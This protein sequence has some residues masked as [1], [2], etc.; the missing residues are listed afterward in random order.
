MVAINARVGSA[1]TIQ[2]SLL[3]LERALALYWLRAT[4]VTAPGSRQALG[5]LDVQGLAESVAAQNAFQFTDQGRDRLVTGLRLGRERITAAVRAGSIDTL[6]AAA[7]VEGFRRRLM[8]RAASSDPASVVQ[9]F[10]LVEV[11][12]LGLGEA[13]LPA[14][15]HAWGLS[16]RVIDGR[17]DVRMPSRLAWHELAGRPGQ[18]LLSAHVADLPLRVAEWLAE[19][20]LPAA[21]ARGVLS[22]A[23]WDL[24]VNTQ[25]ADQDDWLSVVRAAQALSA[26]RVADHVSALTAGGP[27]V[28]VGTRPGI[29]GPTPHGLASP[30]QSQEPC[31]NPPVGPGPLKLLGACLM[32][33]GC[34]PGSA[35]TKRRTRFAASRTT[36]REMTR[37][38]AAIVIAAAIAAVRLVAAGAGQAPEPRLRILSPEDGSYAS[39][40]ITIRATVEPPGTAVERMQFFGEGRLV[41]TVE[42]PPFECT[43]NAGPELRERSIR[44]V[45]YLP[46]GRRLP[47]TIH[48]KGVEL[49]LSVDVDVVRVTVVV[50]DGSRFVRGL[51][52][53]AF[54]VFEDD[55]RQPIAYFGAQNVPLEL[56]TGVDVSES[57]IDALEQVKEVVKRFLSALRPTDRVHVVAFNENFFQIA[58]PSVTLEERLRAVDELASWGA[59][60]L[61][62]TIIRSFDL[63]GDQPNRRGMVMF[64][65]GD[66]TASR[67][68]ADAVERRAESSDAVLYMIGQG[69]AV[70]SASLRT[71]CERLAEK[72]G[73]RAF[74]PRRV[75]DLGDT[76]GQILEDLSNQYLL[77]YEPPSATRDD[78]WHRI[79]VEVGDGRY[80][81]RARQGYRFR[82]GG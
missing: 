29:R 2:G 17:F 33:L 80:R 16:T 54:R 31:Q 5:Q 38:R 18:G 10:S 15:L 14:D 82:T 42:K 75:Q 46:G 72:S 9:R 56:V 21:L 6:A 37:R 43:W 19:L 69:R 64:T 27:L 53:S 68:P 59:T 3:G 77:T 24:T 49:N 1:S 73:G 30:G 35:S 25:V 7:G 50:L 70:N 74:F 44:V 40:E 65:D 63:L 71:L 61:H 41:C 4:T 51:P 23:M 39:G 60:A 79:R 62:D 13:P 78:R 67:V 34:A 32:C 20:K 81:V 45:A 26:D 11:L 12:A 66:D 58:R 47:E 48:T 22:S 8:R 52:S 28:P 76:Y 57:M 55:V 36:S